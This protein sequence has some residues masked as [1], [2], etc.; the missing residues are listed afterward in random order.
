V[1]MTNMTGELAVGFVDWNTLPAAS[2]A[3]VNQLFQLCTSRSVLNKQTYEA[4]WVPGAVDYMYSRQGAGAGATPSNDGVRGLL[5]A[6]RG[7]P[8]AASLTLRLTSVLEWVPDLGQSLA[9]NTSPA[10]GTN[11][12]AS[13]A[14]INS[15]FG[16]SWW[17]NLVS[18]AGHG[19]ARFASG[20]VQAVS[21]QAPRLGYRAAQL[22]LTM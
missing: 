6:Y 18:A 8:A 3:T 12:T 22:L 21:H 7:Y 2:S 13:V 10:P 1:S 11:Y 14:N 16:N 17:N 19:A 9:H 5:I 20:A 15:K 4:K